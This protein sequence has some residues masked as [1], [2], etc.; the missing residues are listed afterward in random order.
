VKTSNPTSTE[1]FIN[2]N[3]NKKKNDDDESEGLEIHEI[4]T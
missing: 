2:N 1:F 3:N 4:E